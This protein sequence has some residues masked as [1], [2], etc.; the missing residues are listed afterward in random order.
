MAAGEALTPLTST[1][2]KTRKANFN[3]YVPNALILSSLV[4]CDEKPRYEYINIELFQQHPVCANSR[5]D[6]HTSSEKGGI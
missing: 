6:D 1:M 2:R 3:S 5:K 4:F